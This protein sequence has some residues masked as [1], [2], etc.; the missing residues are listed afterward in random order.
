MSCFLCCSIYT[1]V[2]LVQA[3]YL[4]N[5]FLNLDDTHKMMFLYEKIAYKCSKTCR[6]IL[7]I[8]AIAMTI[9]EKK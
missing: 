2:R 5:F 7:T 1:R 3:E 4:N 8:G 6:D 9:L